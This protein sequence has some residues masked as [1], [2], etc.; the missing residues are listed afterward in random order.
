MHTLLIQV[1]GCLQENV[2]LK[3]KM[4]LKV[5]LLFLNTSFYLETSQLICLSLVRKHLPLSSSCQ[6]RGCYCSEGM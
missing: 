3:S 4:K 2:I 5:F 6:L 1:A